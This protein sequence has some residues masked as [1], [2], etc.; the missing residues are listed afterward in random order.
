MNSAVIINDDHLKLRK[1][2]NHLWESFNWICPNI[3]CTVANHLHYQ[4]HVDDCTID[5]YTSIC[6]NTSLCTWS[7]LSGFG[8]QHCGIQDCGSNYFAVIICKNQTN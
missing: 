2:H 5:K 8:I 6:V 7:N 4:R 3:N 1:P